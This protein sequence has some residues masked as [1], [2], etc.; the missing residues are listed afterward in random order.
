MDAANAP[1][2][3]ASTGLL[4]TFVVAGFFSSLP[5]GRIGREHKPPPQLGHTFASTVSTQS[6]QKVHSKLQ[7][8]ARVESGGSAMAHASQLGRSSSTAVIG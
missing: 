3:S 7:I 5:F 4:T 1:W 8:M 2:A 6:L